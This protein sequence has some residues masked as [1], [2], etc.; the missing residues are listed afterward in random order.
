MRAKQDARHRIDDARSVAVCQDGDE[1]QGR[2]SRFTLLAALHPS[3]SSSTCP[4]QLQCDEGPGPPE[5]ALSHL[6]N[7]LAALRGSG[8]SAP[9]A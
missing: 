8:S 2:Q 6:L 1:G 7:P 4:R 3:R 9:M 5:G